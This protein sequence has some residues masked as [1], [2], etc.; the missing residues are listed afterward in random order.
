MT[1]AVL[2]VDVP[3]GG[4]C[5][6][7]G[8]MAGRHVGRQCA[9]PESRCTCTGFTWRGVRYEMER[10]RGPVAVLGPADDTDDTDDLRRAPEQAGGEA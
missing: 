8:H 3:I 1:R 5:D 7:C 2:D 9:W 4:F 6:Y 10:N